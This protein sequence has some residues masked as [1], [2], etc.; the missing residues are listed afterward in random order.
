MSFIYNYPRPAVTV[1]CLIYSGKGQLKEVLLIKRNN[2]P[3][4]GMW[5]LPGGFL[6]MDE[7]LEQA[8]IRELREETGIG[9]NHLE[10]FH[11]FDRID[12]DPRHRT[13]ST[14]FIGKIDQ[15]RPTVMAGSD[16]GEAGWFNLTHLPRLAFDHEDIIQLAR[17]RNAI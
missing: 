17:K 7:T 14:V 4:K 15:D 2:E 16:A 5:A 9:V 3:F 10:Q 13:I 1:D 12:R 11:T 8:A 6:G